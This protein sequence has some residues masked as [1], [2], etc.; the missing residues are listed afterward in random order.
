MRN[1]IVGFRDK[2]AIFE[3]IVFM[4]IKKHQPKYVYYNGQEIDFFV[5]ETLLEVKYHKKLEGS[6]Y[7]AFKAFNAKQKLI[8]NNCM[9]MEKL[10]EI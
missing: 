9:D 4:K 2:G 3:N 8:I 1:I 6:Q 10:I 5:S 7:D